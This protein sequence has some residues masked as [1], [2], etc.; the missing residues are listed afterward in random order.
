M[1][2]SSPIP[3]HRGDTI[4]TPGGSTGLYV[5]TSPGGIDWIAYDAES[6]PTMC[7]HFDSR[8]GRAYLRG[9]VGPGIVRTAPT[10]AREASAA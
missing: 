9:R 6:F 1:L 10:V 4:T 3:P 2:L 8:E 5:G 7:E